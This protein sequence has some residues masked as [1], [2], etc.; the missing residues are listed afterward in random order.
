[1]PDITVSSKDSDEDSISL[2]STLESEPQE[3]YPLDRI[4]AERNNNGVTEYLVKWQNYPDERCTWEAQTNF[5]N[6]ST[7]P[8]WDHHKLRIKR[9]LEEPY[10]VAA[11]E[12]RVEAWL[13]A[14]KKRKARRRAKRRRRGLSVDPTSPEDSSDSSNKSEEEDN[15]LIN[16]PPR[17]GYRTREA[18]RR[19]LDMH[20][21]EDSSLFVT[22]KSLR[23]RNRTRA[24]KSGYQKFESR[25]N[26]GS[27]DD[28]RKEDTPTG[29]ERSSTEDSLMEDLRSRQPSKSHK[30]KQQLSK[31]HSEA[32]ATTA[33]KRKSNDPIP[34]SAATNSF[35][36]KRQFPK[37]KELPSR[38]LMREASASKAKVPMMGK[39]GSDPARSG[40][41]S[42]SSLAKPQVFGPAIFS[43]WNKGPGPRRG[44]PSL[45]GVLKKGNGKSK[46]FEKLSTR[47]KL[48][49]AGRNE[50]APNIERLVLV[51]P[52]MGL[53]PQK[54]SLSS[55]P[56]ALPSQSPFQMIQE[57]IEK[58]KVTSPVK[59]SS[60]PLPEQPAERPTAKSSKTEDG[61]WPMDT[62]SLGPNLGETDARLVT[63]LPN[64]TKE[65]RYQELQPTKPDY[66]PQGTQTRIQ[67]VSS[68]ENHQFVFASPVERLLPYTPHGLAQPMTLTQLKGDDGMK[69]GP[70]YAQPGMK[71]NVEDFSDI[72]GT[73]N[74][75][76][77]HVK[78]GEVKFRG[79]LPPVKR[80]LLT[81]K[82]PPKT[83]DLWFRQICTAE[84]YKLYFHEV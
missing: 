29:G 74:I 71:H 81:I 37:P 46:P 50:P 5:R 82:I 45:A 38:G 34:Q 79:L 61:D 6:D 84:E 80:L 66:N 1:M 8:E 16:N 69:Q 31:H 70:G 54:A 55:L 75:S 51:N 64:A 36:N 18:R 59:V 10:N 3:E 76:P 2:N 12:A 58:A 63:E 22:S 62:D 35:P 41:K 13:D 65:E 49:K 52:K 72:F 48:S 25:R 44:L 26:S 32:R 4:L 27:T 20:T 68:V 43:N 33:E 14:T 21:D 24:P 11:L 28:Q 47:R 60:E 39:V 17:A 15:E 77:T 67:H 30:G 78:V 83:V 57:S 56:N 53:P 9:G 42:T 23:N 7:I 40:H 73:I 19:N